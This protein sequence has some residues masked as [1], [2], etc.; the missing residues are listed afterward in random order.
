MTP[1]ADRMVE[2]NRARALE[3][4]T[5]I[6]RR[7]LADDRGATAVEYGL[8]CALIFLAIV[9]AVQN[10]S[11]ATRSMYNLIRDNLA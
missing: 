1:M 4:R 9:V 6:L 2:H 5:G 7:F 3:N 10:F 8:I 11:V